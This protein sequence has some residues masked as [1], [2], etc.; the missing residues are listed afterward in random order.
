MSF[1]WISLKYIIVDIAIFAC[2]IVTDFDSLVLDKY[3]HPI[4]KRSIQGN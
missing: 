2:K 4:H 1:Q 3:G